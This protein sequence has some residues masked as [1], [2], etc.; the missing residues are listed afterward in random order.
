MTSTRRPI[1]AMRALALLLALTPQARA[2]DTPVPLTQ[3]ILFVTQIPVPAD[4]TTIGSA[5]GNHLASM[6][7]VG[8]G[9]D[10]WIRY[11]D[12]TL[13]NLTQEAGFGVSGFQGA[14]GIA[15]RDPCVH[16]SGSKA[17]FSMVVG[18]P[19]VQYQQ[20][21]NYWQIY[22]IKGL[23]Q[24]QLPSITRLPHQFDQANNVS[25]IYGTDD[26]IVFTSDRALHGAAHLYPQLDEYE[27]A[28]TITGIWSMDPLL[29]DRFLL[30]P[31]ASGDF[32]LSIDSFG[33][34]IF[35][36]WDHLQRDQQADA[37]NGGG[38]SVY[39]TFNW[40]DE[41]ATAQ[42]LSSNSEVFPEPRSNS[43]DLDPF[44]NVIGH[45]L[46]QFFP[47]MIREDGTEL[48]TL[49]HVG[50]HELREYFDRSFND[51]PALIE[52]I[53]GVSGASNPNRIEN[54]L[55]IQEDPIVP[56]RYLGVS[57]PEF[58]T[59]AAGQI[60]AISLPPDADPDGLVTEYVTHPDTA[61]PSSTPGPDHSGL[62]RD[63]AALSDGTLIA[64][65]TSETSADANTGSRELPGSKYDFRLKLVAPQGAGGY[66][67]GG[68]MLTPGI[69]KTISYYDPDVL[70]SYSGEL[71]E[72]QPVEVVARVRTPQ[73][74]AAL[75]VPEQAAFSQARVDYQEFRSWLYQNGLALLVS[76]DLTTRDDSDRQQPFNLRV[77]PS[78][79]QTLGVSG[80]VYDI[81]QV[82]FF[83]GDMLRSLGGPSSPTPGRRILAQ[84]M[85][86]ADGFNPPLP[87]AAPGSVQIAADGSMA[88]VVPARRALSWQLTDPADEPVVRE[89][90]WL[91]F[92]P[93]EVRT[94]SS[95]HGVNAADQAG[96]LPPT[97][98]PQALV[99]L[100]GYWKTLT[101]A[102]PALEPAGAGTV[103]AGLGGPFDVLSINGSAGGAAR[104][105][106]VAS[107]QP[108]EISMGTPPGHAGAAQFQLN[109]FV[110]VPGAMNVFDTFIGPFVFPPP[111]A[112]P[113]IEGFFSLGGGQT[114]WSLNL[115]AGVA[116]SITVT[117]QGYIA[118]SPGAAQPIAVTN[119]VILR[120]Q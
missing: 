41:S 9:G 84:V 48:E 50:R 82:Q 32:S 18:G 10:L 24:G 3:P 59:H 13:R 94:C 119:G 62:Y 115:P 112:A 4:F 107:G 38:G 118:N 28:P 88:A 104:R 85:H 78:G 51:D 95:C 106:D 61:S 64:T 103:G 100:L 35:T 117:L 57:T 75:D 47:W 19:A 22:E 49:N 86:D 54:F 29:G 108:I 45:S 6:Q 33:R 20:T 109:G 66:A 14:D 1:R 114:S 77:A 16:W 26:R 5:F 96:Q 36:R 39:G 37:D 110:G 91:S 71:W 21:T 72:L 12:G 44:G 8:R 81:Q 111:F 99:D 43:P 74:P 63:P 31:S 69:S 40:S 73:A 34:V 55:Q 56:G 97:N 46:N 52:F 113:D 60:V 27:E 116:G 92:Q 25:P 79:T 70:V 105:V 2:A 87:G 93:G 102:E 11:G 65:H 98:T 68:A 15:V 83:Q 120:V 23:G 7:A 53:A 67:V 101:P 58:K 42:A 90:Y 30:T 76:R 80:P 89:R 17:L